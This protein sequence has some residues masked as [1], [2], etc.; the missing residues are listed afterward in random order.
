METS[1]GFVTESQQHTS[2]AILRHWSFRRATS[3][4]ERTTIQLLEGAEETG[5]SELTIVLDGLGEPNTPIPA[6]VHP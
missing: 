4:M 1:C 5:I 2:V 3:K 6:V